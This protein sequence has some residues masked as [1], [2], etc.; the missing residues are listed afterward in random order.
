MATMAL[1]GCANAGVRALRHRR[2]NQHQA[3]RHHLPPRGQG[4]VPRAASRRLAVQSQLQD[5]DRALL[6]ISKRLSSA[7]RYGSRH[8]AVRVRS[9]PPLVARAGC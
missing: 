3:P 1:P 6:D 7:T 2:G 8:P 5:R 4:P 9:A